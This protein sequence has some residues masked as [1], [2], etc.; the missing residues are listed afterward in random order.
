MRSRRFIQLPNGEG[1]CSTW[2]DVDDIVAINETKAGCLI[3]IEGIELP[4]IT[5]LNGRDVIDLI[6]ET[7]RRENDR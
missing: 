3:Y 1:D 4:A 2:I 7:Y 5:V 6:V